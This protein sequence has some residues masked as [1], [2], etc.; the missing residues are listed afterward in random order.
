MCAP[1]AVRFWNGMPGVRITRRGMMSDHV[2]CAR[3]ASRPSVSGLRRNDHP[4]VRVWRKGVHNRCMPLTLR[5]ARLIP[6][7]L[8]VKHCWMGLK[9]GYVVVGVVGRWL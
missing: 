1:L 8:V 5:V 4:I 9:N 7:G 6:L 3:P 2:T